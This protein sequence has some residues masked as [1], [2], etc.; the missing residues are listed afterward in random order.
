V[1][2]E[3]KGEE[4]SRHER[5][6][7]EKKEQSV[8]ERSRTDWT[9]QDRTDRT[10]NGPYQSK[11]VHDWSGLVGSSPVQSGLVQPGLVWSVGPVWSGPVWSGPDIQVGWSGIRS[12]PVWSSLV[13]S[14]LV[15]SSLVWSGLV[16]SIP[17]GLV[18]SGLV[19][20]LVQ[21]VRSGSFWISGLVL[22]PAG[23]VHVLLVC[24]NTTQCWL[25]HSF[26]SAFV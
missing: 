16:R 20:C 11:T 8:A 10:K 13:L 5:R 1:E 24:T 23:A 15:R 9:G 17:V 12:G 21:S 3:R 7:E 25:V 19:W 14:G 2:R 22:G 4:W 26:V 6:G 18:R